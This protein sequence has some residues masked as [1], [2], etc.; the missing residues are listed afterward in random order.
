[1]P[2]GSTLVCMHQG[3]AMIADGLYKD[4]ALSKAVRTQCEP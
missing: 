4:V 2:Q 1:M 3:L